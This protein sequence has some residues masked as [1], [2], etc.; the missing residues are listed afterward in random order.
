[1]PIPSSQLGLIAGSRTGYGDGYSRFD[2]RVLPFNVLDFGVVP[3]LAVFQT[4]SI[5]DAIDHAY[6]QGGGTVFI[7]AGAYA[8]QS[9]RM[10]PKVFLVGAGGNAQGATEVTTLH[11]ATAT[12]VIITMA[13]ENVGDSSG[14]GIIDLRVANGIGNANNA[15]GILVQGM[16]H[17]TLRRVTVTQARLFGI[18]FTG[19]P[20]AGGKMYNNLWDCSVVSMQNATDACYSVI[21]DDAG[22]RPDALTLWQC[23]A[24]SDS[25]WLEVLRGAF[26]APD[27]IKAKMCNFIGSVSIANCLDLRGVNARIESCR[28]ET[29][30]GGATLSVNL[31]PPA[32]S[33]P[34]A[35]LEGNTWSAPG[36]TTFV[37]TGTGTARSP[38][39]DDFDGT[40]RVTATVVTQSPAALGAGNNNNYALPSGSDPLTARVTS[41]GAGS[42]LTGIAG[43]YDGRRVR[44][45]HIAGL[46]LTINHQDANSAAA[47]R[48]IIPDAAA[49]ALTID[50]T[51]DLEYDSTS[52]RWRLINWQL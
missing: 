16:S 51:A 37:D 39:I 42:V 1:M 13:P 30:G 33:Q 3:T 7:P 22:S 40:S 45:V 46:T 23:H 32:G 34:A 18:R 19:G 43:G 49:K 38:R 10:Y 5:Q 4:R 17:V 9:L 6:K 27:S 15:G 28:L 47:N 14:G 52:L 35:S 29:V 48:I 20:L 11:F 41:N 2:S 50:G 12:G 26:N 24:N 31:D 8:T 36:G 25:I 44:I 21:A